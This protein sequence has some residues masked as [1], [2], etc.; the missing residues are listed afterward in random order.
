MRTSAVVLSI[1]CKLN[2]PWTVAVLRVM[3]SK[4]VFD[5]AAVLGIAEAL[6]NEYARPLG[7][8]VSLL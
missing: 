4:D 2:L 6:G 3:K 5:K 8:Y 1:T 7:S